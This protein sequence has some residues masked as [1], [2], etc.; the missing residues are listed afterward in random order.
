MK[1][2]PLEP[3]KEAIIGEFLA[4]LEEKWQVSGEEIQQIL[5]KKTIGPQIPISVFST[6]A[7]TALET[8]CK[9][10]H[11]NLQLTFSQAARLLNRDPRLIATTCHRAHHK[12]PKRFVPKPSSFSITPSLFKNRTLSPLENLVFYL[13]EN[14][15]LTFHT[16]ALLLHRDDSTIWTVYQR[17]KKKHEA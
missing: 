16:I 3:D 14:R 6:D 2:R 8:A 10:L 13:K 5:E 12:F 17:A 4:Y 15:Q 1:K 7:L 9:Y 11:E